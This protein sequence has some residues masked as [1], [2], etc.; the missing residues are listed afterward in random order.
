[1]ATTFTTARPSERTSISVI[2]VNHVSRRINFVSVILYTMHVSSGHEL[3]RHKVMGVP[4]S[5]NLTPAYANNNNITTTGFIT[6]FAG[7]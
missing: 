2:Y 5:F 3:G 7:A 6:W 4:N 1:M